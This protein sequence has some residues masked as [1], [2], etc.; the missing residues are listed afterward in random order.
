[1]DAAKPALIAAI[2]HRAHELPSD[3]AV[4]DMGI[5]GDGTDAGDLV[6]L[7]ETVAAHDAATILGDDAVEA[8]IAE[9]QA[10]D[11]DSELLAGHFVWEVVLLRYR[12]ERFVEDAAAGADVVRCGRSDADG[13]IHSTPPSSP[14]APAPRSLRVLLRFERHDGQDRTRV[15]GDL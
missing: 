15:R 11:P 5:D 9:Q 7:V 14:L 6:A 2:D 8:G 10:D 1:T 13:T 4:L 12:A 3:P